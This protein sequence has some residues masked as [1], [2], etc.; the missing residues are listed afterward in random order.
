VTITFI[1]F[2]YPYQF[3]YIILGEVI[4]IKKYVLKIGLI[5]VF[6]SSALAPICIGINVEQSNNE[7]SQRTLFENS[8]Q[9]PMYKHNPQHTGRSPFDA[10]GNPGHEKWKYFVNSSITSTV[11]IDSDKTIYAG[12]NMRELHAVYPNGTRKWKQ[13]LVNAHSYDPAIGHDGTIYI[14]TSEK[15][16]AF[17]PDG[18]LKW[19]L[20]KDNNFVG[21]PVEDD[22]GV[23]YI[24]SADGH[25]Y[26][27][28]PNG[29]IKWEFFI[30][31]EDYVSSPAID[32]QGNII[33]TTFN[34]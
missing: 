4:S 8:H 18:T 20:D 25:L 28:Y 31:S 34:Q 22:D 14:G 2:I 12:A 9:W 27:I 3:N 29:T 30:G 15:F 33:I 6:I 17:K 16:H 32:S 21:C 23:V 1:L 7:T 5:L 10:S 11:V 13:D 24:G 19:I 26:A